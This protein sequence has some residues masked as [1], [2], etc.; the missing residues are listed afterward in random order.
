MNYPSTSAST[1]T[2]KLEGVVGL[3]TSPLD[4][5]FCRAASA[6]PGTVCSHCYSCDMLT[7]HRQ[8]CR[9]PWSRNGDN[10]SRKLW[11]TDALPTL[12]G[13]VRVHAHGELLNL[14]HAR[15]LWRIVRNSEFGRF[16]WFTKRP[17]LVARAAKLER[18]TDTER[19]RVSVVQSSKHCNAPAEPHPI[20]DHTYTAYTTA[21]PD[22][23]FHCTSQRCAKCAVCF[24]RKGPRAIA[25]PLRRA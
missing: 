7:G 19:G 24:V 21:L 22:D 14:T 1:M 2:G 4:N 17:S 18:V 12:S 8:N 13:L 15:N 16:A 3:N 23:A 5:A 9:A 10:L 20:V 11:H 25:A 6:E